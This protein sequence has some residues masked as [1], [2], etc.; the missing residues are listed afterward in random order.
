MV[1]TRDIIWTTFLH[2]NDHNLVLPGF[3][4]GQRGESACGHRVLISPTRV[5]GRFSVEAGPRVLM[6]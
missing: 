6:E 5:F 1:L 3:Q 4:H 2:F